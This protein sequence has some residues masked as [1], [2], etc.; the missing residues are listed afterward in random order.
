MCHCSFTIFLKV[1][2]MKKV[3]RADG[4]DYVFKIFYVQNPH[5]QIFSIRHF[6]F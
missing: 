6:V 3:S 2:E 5:H 4:K 1:T